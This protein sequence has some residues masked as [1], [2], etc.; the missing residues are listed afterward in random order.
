[1]I[2]NLFF[3]SFLIFKK[4]TLFF[5][6]LQWDQLLL[7]SGFREKGLDL[8]YLLCKPKKLAKF[9]FQLFLIFKIGCL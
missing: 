1:M 2:K 3:V 6:K 7:I 9:P 4:L 5:D 8:L